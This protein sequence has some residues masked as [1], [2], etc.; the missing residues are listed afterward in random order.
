MIVSFITSAA[1]QEK[2][3]KNLIAMKKPEQLQ[4][5]LDKVR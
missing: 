4:L 5:T 1:G 3:K 2:E